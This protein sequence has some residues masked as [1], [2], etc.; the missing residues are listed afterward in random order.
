M[1]GKLVGLQE[2]FDTVRQWLDGDLQATPPAS[3]A[4]QLAQLFGLDEFQ[5]NVLLLSAYATLEAGAA[6]HLKQLHGDNNTD[7]VSIGLTLARLPGANWSALSASAPLRHCGLIQMSG[8]S[9]IVGQRIDISESTLFYLLGAPSLSVELESLSRS[10]TVPQKLAPNR[11]GLANKIVN[12]LQVS[13]NTI[14][15]LSGPDP[16]GKEQAIAVACEQLNMQVFHINAAALPAGSG[17]IA[18]IAHSWRR[19][20]KLVDGYL[21]I[22]AANIPNENALGLFVEILGAGV[23]IAAT[24]PVNL[25]NR[26]FVSVDM[27]RMTASEQLPMWEDELGPVAKHLNGSVEKLSSFFTV[28]PELVSNVASELKNF[29]DVNDTALEPEQVSNKQLDDLAW[30]ACRRFSRPGMDDLARRVESSVS[31]ADLILPVRQ[32]NVLDAIVTHVK[33]RVR[34]NEEWGF[35]QRHMGRGLGVSALFA[36]PSGA[37][38]SMAGEVLGKE[39]GLDV[40]R[41]DL[42]SIVSKWVGETEKN[43][44]RVFD[45]AENGCAILQ[46]DEADALFGKRSE[47]KDSHDRHSNIEVSYLLQRLEE[48]RGLTILTTNLRHNIDEAFIRRIR[49]IIDFDFPSSSERIAIW[50]HIFPKTA[51]LGP[52]SYERLGQLQLTGGSIRNVALSAAFL[53]A[54]AGQEICMHHIQAA[55]RLDYDKIGRIITDDELRGWS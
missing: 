33:N 38:K 26:S 50:E 5:R 21:F 29:L 44:R 35:G 49:F 55:A 51:P 32:N 16:K 9:N 28:T 46:F 15:Q 24:E 36:G 45:A 20:L 31:R 43:L 27:P 11:S 47:V 39:L 25:G 30:E 1:S 40:Y 52:L 4:D 19:D 7:Y 22:D 41:V 34:V 42:S 54:E 23:S 3:R 12:H 8:A 37:G 13:L 10:L 18:A 14:L 53:A 17:D 2:C 48:Y 6:D